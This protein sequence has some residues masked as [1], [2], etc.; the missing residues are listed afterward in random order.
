MRCVRRLS[1]AMLLCTAS[2][3]DAEDGTICADRPGKT[4]S[5]CT[6]PAGHFQIETAFADYTLQKTAGERDPLLT[7][8]ETTFK[9][10]LSGD[11]D[12]ELDVTPWAQG[13]SRSG[14]SHSQVSGI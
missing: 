11:T 4:T 9:Y 3:A 7:I 1:L 6:V 5:P 14:G 8:G 13:T 12:V 10:G 2:A